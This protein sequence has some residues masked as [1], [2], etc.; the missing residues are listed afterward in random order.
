VPN[1]SRT[2]WVGAPAQHLIVK[3]HAAL[4]PQSFMNRGRDLEDLWRRGHVTAVYV[5]ETPIDALY[6]PVMGD[7]RAILA[8]AANA[9]VVAR[10]AGANPI[11]VHCLAVK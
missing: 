2:L 6:A 8:M 1:D 9:E 4:P 11:V 3:G 10:S 7:V 5:L